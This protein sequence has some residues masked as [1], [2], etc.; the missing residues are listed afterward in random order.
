MYKDLHRIEDALLPCLFH[1][2][3]KCHI[4]ECPE[5]AEYYEKALHI[6]D[7]T[8]ERC[9]VGLPLKKKE[10]LIR[11]LNR[12]RY[13][14]NEYFVGNKFHVRKMFLTLAEWARVLIEANAIEY[15]DDSRFWEY[16]EDLG[17]IIIKNGYGEIE[18][19]DK[20]D[21]SAIDHVPKV[22]KIAQKEGYFLA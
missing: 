6:L 22:H 21:A 20:I 3:S 7:E 17:E 18:N 10:S 19:F 13:I 11:R 9:F 12:A 5:V 15:P 8:I 1:W 2:A 14:I 4:D 16:L